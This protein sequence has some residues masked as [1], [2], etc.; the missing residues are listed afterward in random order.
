MDEVALMRKSPPPS[1]RQRYGLIATRRSR[2]P[3][4]EK[5]RKTVAALPRAWVGHLVVRDPISWVTTAPRVAIHM[6]P[7]A[8]TMAMH[9][10]DEV[11]LMRKSPPP[12]Q[13]QRYGLI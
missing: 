8:S 4:A 5:Q 1:Q 12:S 7:R 2:Q 10:M 3:R 13:R 11:A 9:I 6:M